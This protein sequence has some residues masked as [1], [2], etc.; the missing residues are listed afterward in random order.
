LRAEWFR[1]HHATAVVFGAAPEVRAELARV[2][3]STAAINDDVI[4][5]GAPP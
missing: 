3:S 5:F 1:G 2:A 4:V